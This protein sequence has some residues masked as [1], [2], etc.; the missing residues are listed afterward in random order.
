[1][2]YAQDPLGGNDV[3]SNTPVEVRPVSINDILETLHL[4]NETRPPIGRMSSDS[5]YRALMIEST[6][7]KGLWWLVAV[8]GDVVVGFIVAHKS[9]RSFWQRY[10]SRHP[11][12][13]SNLIAHECARHIRYALRSREGQGSDSDS[14][15]RPVESEPDGPRWSDDA[16]YV[17]KAV[18]IY[19]AT[20]HRGRGI[21]G[22]LND[23]L[24]HTLMREGV[25]RLDLHIDL[26]N[27]ASVRLAQK[28]GWTVRREQSGYLVIV[29]LNDKND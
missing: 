6:K 14:L 13:L 21:G 7:G 9:G 28:S 25:K 17:A 2:A 8:E 10:L 18:L 3:S 16:P 19:I 15:P 29:N 24:V 4:L 1:M 20:Q 23:A 12:L 11:V 27:N 26:G 22:K 5:S